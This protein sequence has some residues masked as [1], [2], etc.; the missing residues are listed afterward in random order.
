MMKKLSKE[1]IA[2]IPELLKTK[3]TEEL[4]TEYGVSKQNINYWINRFKSKGVVIEVF[5]KD[6]LLERIIKENTYETTPVI[7][8]GEETKG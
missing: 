4:A 7:K 3:T 5:K 2:K 1:Q 8:E 6:S